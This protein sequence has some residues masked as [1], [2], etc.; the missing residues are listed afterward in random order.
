MGA[1]LCSCLNVPRKPASGCLTRSPV[2]AFSSGMNMDARSRS[3]V[4]LRAQFP[5]LIH[6]SQ[7]CGVIPSSRRTE[8]S[9]A[10]PSHTHLSWYHFLQKR[11]HAHLSKCL[12][13]EAMRS[14]ASAL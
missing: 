5:T 4:I 8:R 9:G 14:R 13:L 10:H 6:M 3:S 12:A 2:R 11:T 1:A 7:A